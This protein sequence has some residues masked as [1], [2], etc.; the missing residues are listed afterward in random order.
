MWQPICA[1]FNVVLYHTS[2]VFWSTLLIRFGDTLRHFGPEFGSRYQPQ[3]HWIGPHTGRMTT[4]I[5]GSCKLSKNHLSDQPIRLR[6]DLCFRG[7]L[8]IHHRAASQ[9]AAPRSWRTFCK[10]ARVAV[11]EAFVASTVFCEGERRRSRAPWRCRCFPRPQGQCLTLTLHCDTST[12]PEHFLSC[13]YI[14]ESCNCP[15][16]LKDH[17]TEKL[18][19]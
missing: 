4:P 9:L 17:T 14:L 15:K 18:R 16:T 7:V 8:L 3:Q 5:P 12:Q 1:L 6:P 19:A 11:M 10:R 2:G 13:S